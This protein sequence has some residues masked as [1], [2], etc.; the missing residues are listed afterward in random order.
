MGR[1]F[2]PATL[3]LW[4]KDEP[5][6]A[7]VSFTLAVGSSVTAFG[8][9]GRDEVLAVRDVHTVTVLAGSPEDRASPERRFQL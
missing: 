7:V 8:C 9:P 2:P 1:V 6:S 5:A 4:A 3:M